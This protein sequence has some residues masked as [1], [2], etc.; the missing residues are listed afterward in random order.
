MSKIKLA[1]LASGSG[2]NAEAIM[3]W[4]ATSDIAE[5]VCVGSNKKAA[6][7]IS[8]AEIFNIPKFT[9]LK[10]KNES[11]ESYDERMSGALSEYKPDWIILAGFMRLLTES[12]LEKFN[13]QVINIHPSLLPM[14]PGLDGYGDAFKAGVIESGC[15]VHYVDAGLDSGAIIEQRIF[16]MIPGESFEDF[17]KRGLSIE[18]KFYP[19]VLEK[20]FK[21]KL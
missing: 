7:V 16:P 13:H 19:E 10:K 4:A 2:S 20:L 6:M 21:G 15:T 9:V 1:I 17:K 12:F 3:K 18:N 11:R 14:F 5:V 8:R